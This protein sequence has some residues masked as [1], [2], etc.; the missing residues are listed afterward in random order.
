MK[1]H[2]RTFRLMVPLKLII[3]L[4]LKTLL[5]VKTIET[6]TKYLKIIPLYVYIIKTTNI[7]E[8]V[9]F[10]FK[11]IKQIEH[12]K[13]FMQKLNLKKGVYHRFNS[14]LL[15]VSLDLQVILCL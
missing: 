8:N 15:S 14:G 2:N 5:L 11:R 3:M 13:G 9:F 12:K 6:V 1:N 4:E 7:L 10:I